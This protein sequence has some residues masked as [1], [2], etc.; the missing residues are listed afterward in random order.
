M[1]ENSMSADVSPHPL[2][3]LH[4]RPQLTRER[5]RSLDGPWAFALDPQGVWTHPSEVQFDLEIRVPFC[6]ESAASGLSETGYHRSVW[7]KRTVALE[8]YERQDTLKLH[9]GAVD[10]AARVWVGGE[11]VASHE[12][13]H[14]P[15]S[16]DLSAHAA[17]SDTLEI[18]VQAIDDPHD[19]SLARGKQDWKEEAHD[20]WYPR[21]TGIWQT[22]WLESLPSTFIESLRWTPHLERWELGLEVRL[23]GPIRSGTRLRLRLTH[24]DEELAEDTYKLVGHELHRRVSLTDPGIDSARSELLWSPEHPHLID[25]TLELLEQDEMGGER[26]VDRVGSYTALRSVGVQD[27]RFLLNGRPYTLKMVLD[28]GYWPDTLMTPPSSEALMLDVELTKRLG[29]NGARKHQKIEDPRYLYWCDTLGLLVWEEMPSAYRFSPAGAAH[30]M[31]EWLEVLSRDYSHPCV[32]AWVPFNESWGVPDLPRSRE[33]R[34]LV[35]GFYHTT[36]ALDATRVVI[37]NDGWEH[38]ATDLLTIHDYTQKP[39]K[40]F[41]RYGTLAALRQT[42]LEEQPAGRVLHT[43]DLQTSGLPAMLSEFGGMAYS[44]EEGPSWGYHRAGDS[45]ALLAQFESLLGAV[46]ACHPALI[47]FCYTQLTDTFQ[48]KNGLLTARREPK[49]P[50]AALAQATRGERHLWDLEKD[51]DPDPLGYSREWRA[52]KKPEVSS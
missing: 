49:A 40:I 34:H 38:L 9:F 5:W 32:V 3:P 44:L 19:L 39:E 13:G 30:L 26:I 46:R 25:A 6:P 15:F 18:V 45:Q 37:G 20:I 21:T 16:A 52:R 28:Q 31:R 22:V 48:E 47:G 8:L 43:P 36:K 12:G 23:A 50:L 10:Y 7:Y 17:K 35:S 24:G 4:P 42:L 11:L 14:T 51:P 2:T 27:G 1:F 33:H 41:A 29:F